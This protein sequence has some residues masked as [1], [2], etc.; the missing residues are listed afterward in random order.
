MWM[1]SFSMGQMYECP[2]ATHGVRGVTVIHYRPV[3]EIRIVG[4]IQ[5][6]KAQNLFMLVS[7]W[8]FSWS[9]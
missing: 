1:S 2:L 4:K 3:G 5:F 6:P 7:T 9:A 8:L